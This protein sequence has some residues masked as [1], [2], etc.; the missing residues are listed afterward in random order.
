MTVALLWHRWAS[1]GSLVTY[2]AH[3]FITANKLAECAIGRH[4]SIAHLKKSSPFSFGFD[5]SVQNRLM[6]TPFNVSIT[7]S[8]CWRWRFL[9]WYTSSAFLWRFFG[10]PW[11]LGELQVKA[12]DQTFAF[13]FFLFCPSSREEWL[14]PVV[15]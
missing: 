13:G 4:G 14:L 8:S 11:G 6:I 3:Y 5:V 1:S 10:R 15:G 2:E 12:T 7:L 9:A